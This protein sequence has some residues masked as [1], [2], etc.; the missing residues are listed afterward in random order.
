[1]SPQV[2]GMIT[3]YNP[4]HLG[5]EYHITQTRKRLGAET[6]VAVM[7]GSF[8]QRGEP[9]VLDKWTRAENAVLGGVDLVIELPALF[10]VSSAEYFASAGVHLLNQLGLVDSLSF[11]SESG[12]IE[13][14]RA[15]AVSVSHLDMNWKSARKSYPELSYPALRAKLLSEAGLTAAESPNDILG[16]EYIKAID[17]LEASLQPFTLQRSGH[18]YHDLTLERARPE[19]IYSSASAIRSALLSGAPA[20]SVAHTVPNHTL[21]ALIR[22]CGHFPN[23]QKRFE[24]LRYRLLLHT[25][26][27]LSLIHDMEDGLPERILAAA[28]KAADYEALVD[29][30]KSKRYTRSRIERVLAKILLEIPETQIGRNRDILPAYIRVL[31]FNDR[32]R[33]LLKKAGNTSGLPIL[34]KVTPNDLKRPVIGDQLRFDLRA[35]DLRDMLCGRSEAARDLTHPPV[36]VR[37]FIS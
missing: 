13:T 25:P 16:V 17:A 33:A 19:I 6:V 30:I 8:V 20:E 26:E 12:E 35:T 29:A 24:W 23:N 2:A 4:F 34:T 1:M 27:S 37:S 32:G 28:K 15:C 36:Y 7:S 14:L 31:A 11:G 10:A 21:A 3:E 18:G 9:A 22:A 5:H